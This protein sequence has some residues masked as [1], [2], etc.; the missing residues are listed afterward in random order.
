MLLPKLNCLVAEVRQDREQNGKKESLSMLI[1]PAIY[2]AGKSVDA[3]L[4][5]PRDLNGD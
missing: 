2:T 4:H 1:N 3:T 5:Y